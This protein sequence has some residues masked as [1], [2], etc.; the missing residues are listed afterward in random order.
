MELTVPFEDNME[1]AA[2]LKKTKYEELA[3]ETKKSN[4]NTVVW[5]VEV[6]CR[7]FSGSSLLRFLKELGYNGKKRTQ[8]IKKVE[9]EAENAS[10]MIWNWSHMQ[11][12]G[13]SN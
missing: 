11:E 3:E 4:W 10:H 12:W 6:G 13:N 7:G 1:I 5:T 8:I 2:E 9:A